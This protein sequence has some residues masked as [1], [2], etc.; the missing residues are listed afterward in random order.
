MKTKLEVIIEMPDGVQRDEFHGL[1][2]R[3]VKWEVTRCLETQLPAMLV[4]FGHPRPRITVEV[5]WLPNFQPQ[6]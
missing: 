5:S 1:T 6:P 4:T 3:D 2:D